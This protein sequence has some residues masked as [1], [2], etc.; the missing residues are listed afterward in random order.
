MVGHYKLLEHI[1]TGGLGEVYRARDTRLGR[2]VAIKFPPPSLMADPVRREALL[3]HAAAMARLSHPS[4]ATLFE[5]GE[6][7]DRIYLVFEYVPG[8]YLSGVIAG[9]PLNPRRA[10]EFGIQLADA[11]GEAHAEELVHGDIHADSI[12]VTPKD[13]A[14]LLDFGFARSLAP[15]AQAE[16]SSPSD[17]ILAVGCVLFE[18]LTGRRPFTASPRQAAPRASAVTPGVP[19]ELDPILA[20]AVALDPGVRY[21]T[22]ATLA[23]ELRGVAAILDIRTAANEAE[24][25]DERPAARD[26]LRPALFVLV[27]VSLV[28]AGSWIWREDAR[29][30]WHR[31]FGPPPAPVVVVAPFDLDG[32]PAIIADGI[33]ED[34]AMRLGTVSGLRVVGRSSLRSSRGRDPVEIARHARA[35]VA[36]TGTIGVDGDRITLDTAMIDAQTGMTLWR[37]RFSSSKAQLLATEASIME[38]VAQAVGLT[39]AG[40]GEYD[41]TASRVVNPSA[42]DLYL[43]GRDADSRGD[44]TGA[45]RLYEQATAA[46]GSLAECHAALAVALYR[47]SGGLHPRRDQESLQRLR[48]AAENAVTADPDLPAAHIAAG[49]A[50]P[51]MREALPSFQRAARLDPSGADSYRELADQVGK[52]D[53]DRAAALRHALSELDA[54]LLIAEESHPASR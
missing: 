29:R 40:G 19:V 48:R 42:Y 13:R 44:L 25:A 34:L 50:A 8:D 28:A 49:L 31:W 18:M 54:K 32:V 23:A 41:R 2:T 10:I 47:Q 21:Q 6:E 46:D 36:L 14:K 26:R 39:T 37:H 27:M 53:P 1:G 17:D 4:I 22:A 51:A 33:A 52:F 16:A 45:I 35:A 11:L 43:Q 30:Q 20:R 24:L 38:R 12:L 15:E 7:N 9:R 5:V 3:R